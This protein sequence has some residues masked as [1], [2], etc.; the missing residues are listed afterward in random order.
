MTSLDLLVASYALTC[1]IYLVFF[2]WLVIRG[3]IRTLSQRAFAAWILFLALTSMTGT[4]WHASASFD[5]AFLLCRIDFTVLL[6]SALMIWLFSI[7]FH[8]DLRGVDFFSLIPA[9]VVIPLIWTVMVSS[10]EQTSLG[11]NAVVTGWFVLFAFVHFGYYIAASVQLA[12]VLRVVKKSRD[13]VAVRR[14]SM[15]LGSVIAL[16]VLGISTP[17]SFTFL[18]VDWLPSVINLCL[19]IPPFL[20]ASTFLTDNR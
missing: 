9:I 2:I 16:T 18:G 12:I 19:G 8:R 20:M 7:L 17:L 6:I 10:V 1:S 3:L 11:L 15:L 13:T 4:I 14:V 5:T